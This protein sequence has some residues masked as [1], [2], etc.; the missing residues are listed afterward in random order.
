MDKAEFDKFADAYQAMHKTGIRMS[1]EEPEYFAEYK[2]ADIARQFER[3]HGSKPS[4]LEIL[5]FGAGVGGSIPF[6]SRYFAGCN[7][8]CLDPSERS[9]EIAEARYPKAATYHPFDGR[10]IPFGDGSFDIAYAMC[11]FHH[12][13][14]DEHVGLMKELRRVLKPGGLLFIFE[15]NPYNPLTVHVV[16]SCPIDENAVLIPGKQLVRRLSQA[17]FASPAIH[18]RIFFPNILRFM[19][20]LEAAL[21]SVPLGAQYYAMSRR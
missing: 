3:L 21:E 18:Y 1:G 14:A 16:N 19:R 8:K 13:E 15:H 10:T 5:D 11:V 2:I 20:P 7:L 6:V 4:G 12:I 17:G 9:L